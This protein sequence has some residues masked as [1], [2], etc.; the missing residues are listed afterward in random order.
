MAGLLLSERAL[1][2][3][4]RW[5]LAATVVMVALVV[6]VRLLG[7][8]R[9]V[10]PSSARGPPMKLAIEAPPA[11][12]V[13]TVS[14][15]NGSP[16]SRAGV[17]ATC[18]SCSPTDDELHV[19]TATDGAGAFAL[20]GL[21]PIGYRVVAHARGFAPGRA[22][23]GEPI[24]LASNETKR[25]VDIVLGEDGVELSGV[26]M[27]AHGSSVIGADVRVVRWEDS[28]SAVTVRTDS[29]GRF[30]TFVP[31]GDTT[32]V[33]SA[34]G[35]SSTRLLR[36]APSRD[37][38]LVL[39]PAGSA[40]GTVIDAASGRPIEGALVRALRVGFPIVPS[41]RAVPTGPNGSFHM[42][43]LDPGK[44]VFDAVAPA[45]RG[46]S[47]RI[48]AV[49]AGRAISGFTIRVSKVARVRG[50]VSSG[51]VGTP[52]REGMVELGPMPPERAQRPPA[53]GAPQSP[54]LSVFAPIGATGEV[55]FDALPKGTYFARVGCR[56]HLLREGPEVVQVDAKDLT[57][58]EWRVE[59]GTGL[60]I[61]SVDESGRPVPRAQVAI[62][63]PNPASARGDAVRVMPVTTDLLGRYRT[64]PNLEPG[65]YVLTSH[66]NYRA[67]PLELVLGNGK[68]MA[69]ATLRI[70]GESG[71]LIRVHEPRGEAIDGLTVEAYVAPEQRVSAGQQHRLQA[72][73]LGSGRYAIG[74]IDP[75]AY[76]V[77]VRDDRN[78]PIVAT[79]AG[80]ETFTVSRGTTIESKVVLS[81]EGAITGR[82]IDADSRPVP[83]VWVGVERGEKGLAGMTTRMMRAL[84]VAGRALTDHEG[85]FKLD[86]LLSHAS[87]DLRAESSDGRSVLSG[88]V[89]AGSD[90]VL[91]LPRV[92]GVT[93][94]GN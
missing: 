77:E 61:A 36:V 38:R 14:S 7:G 57:G 70:L 92:L 19:C 63:L 13:G 32:L 66:D 87:F 11:T 67:D 31:P 71:L 23:N 78:P 48:L 22:Q 10:A 89:R 76:R 24:F 43:R 20:T 58:L 50:R 91:H 65:R 42:G 9:T 29:D 55:N 39:G 4:V 64:P 40:S 27:N 6:T 59:P 81:R 86:Q 88:S 45:Y 84:G 8:R 93:D 5:S 79:H 62:R 1:R 51:S 3:T 53:V 72:R 68:G 90:L 75:G 94:A 12:L 17:C 60:S 54:V 83:G 49:R 35:Y 30:V 74:P 26:V 41:Q 21:R 73:A 25:G 2:R 16:V 15:R 85:R 18:I 37:V 80:V 52:C 46:Q 33:A 47:E 82:V 56:D 34:E 44:Y 69:P 28:P